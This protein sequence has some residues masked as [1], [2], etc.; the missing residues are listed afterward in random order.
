MNIRSDLNSKEIEK[1]KK[2][3]IRYVEVIEDVVILIR[4]YTVIKYI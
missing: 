3:I 2:E 1:M 4:L